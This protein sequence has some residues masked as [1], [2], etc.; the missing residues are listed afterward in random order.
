MPTQNSGLGYGGSWVSFAS[1]TG[2]LPGHANVDTA[3]EETSN[4][5]A[6]FSVS[7]S[8]TLASQSWGDPSVVH[9]G[10]TQE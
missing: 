5:V 3:E 6:G 7:V 4:G 8:R 1:C 10:K 2:H 9:L